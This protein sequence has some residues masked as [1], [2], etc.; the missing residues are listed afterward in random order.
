MKLNANSLLLAVAVVLAP[1]LGGLLSP[2]PVWAAP[3]DPPVALQISGFKRPQGVD[4]DP[5]GNIFVADTENHVVKKFDPSGSLIA[6]WGGLGSGQS[7]FRYPRDVA[8]GPDGRV[9]VAD[10]VNDRVQGLSA[11][12][13]VH[14][15]PRC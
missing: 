10:T 12:G 8:V 5:Q 1:L 14:L 13:G 15:A 7:N 9:Y 2:S 6:Q 3:G 11:S 4:V